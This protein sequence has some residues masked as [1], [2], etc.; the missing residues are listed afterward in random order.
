MKF[1]TFSPL[2]RKSQ[3][4]GVFRNGRVFD[5]QPLIGGGGSD[6]VPGSLLELIQAGPTVWQS[7]AALLEQA[8][9]EPSSA[10]AGYAPEAVRWHAPISRPTKNIVCLGLNY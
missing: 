3:R 10:Q 4:L 8:F 9:R 1:A 6:P 5:V 2:D 7:V